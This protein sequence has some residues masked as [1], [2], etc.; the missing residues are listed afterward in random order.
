MPMVKVSLPA[1]LFRR[2]QCPGSWEVWQLPD[3][4]LKLKRQC[5]AEPVAG[6]NTFQRS[7]VSLTMPPRKV[8]LYE[9]WYA[10]SF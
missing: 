2:P 3:G 8:S 5:A 6:W 10:L 4:M 9:R 1:V 7:P